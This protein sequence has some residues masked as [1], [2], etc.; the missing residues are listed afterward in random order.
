MTAPSSP[1]CWTPSGS[2]DWG[3]SGSDP[4]RAVLA[5]KAQ[6][7]AVECGINRLNRHR[8]VASRYDKLAVRSLTT[9]RIA[10]IGEWL[11]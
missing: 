10:A 6:R 8:A 5:D 1:L 11:R 7:H 3:L 9:V 2:L 4:P